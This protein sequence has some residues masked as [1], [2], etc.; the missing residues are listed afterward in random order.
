MKRSFLKNTVLPGFLFLLFLFTAGELSAQQE[1]WKE[2]FPEMRAC[3]PVFNYPVYHADDLWDYID[4]AADNY[5]NYRFED[6]HIA[7]YAKG[8]GKIFF[9]VEVYRHASPLY[10]FG[11]Y[12]SERSPDYHFIDMGTQGFQE[13]GQIYFL[14]GPYYVKV[15]SVDERSKEAKYL[16]TLAK[17]IEQHLEGPTGFPPELNW[18]PENGKVKNAERFISRE[19]LGHEFF[20]SVF[21]ARYDLEGKE[22]TAF[23]SHRAGKESAKKILAQMYKSATGKVPANLR[24]GDRMIKDGYNGNIYLIWKDNVLFGFQDID[25]QALIRSMAAEILD[26]I[27]RK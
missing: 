2:M 9:K 24:E 18:F 16:W 7:E 13:S 4:G 14:K 1:N 26:K 8:K 17:L 19:F 11:I 25:D 6:L 23:I 5:L 12:S 21:T 15:I 27:P 10:A 20:D 3:T 22:F